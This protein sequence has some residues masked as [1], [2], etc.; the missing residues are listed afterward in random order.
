MWEDWNYYFVP[1]AVP[2]KITA[3]KKPDKEQRWRYAVNETI[4]EE[5]NKY[6][7]TL[8]IFK[9]YILLFQ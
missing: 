7:A 3:C 5:K 8:R 4:W 9:Y 2:R 1:E 6:S